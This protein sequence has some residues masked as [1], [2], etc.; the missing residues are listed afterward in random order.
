[1]SIRSEISELEKVRKEAHKELTKD[2]DK[3]NYYPKLAE[4]VKLCDH[5]DRVGV[6]MAS[7]NYV[8]YRCCSCKKELWQG[9]ISDIPEEYKNVRISQ[10]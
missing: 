8:R 10:F 4:L 7:K 3:E 5:T 2:W 9:K 1:M 6:L